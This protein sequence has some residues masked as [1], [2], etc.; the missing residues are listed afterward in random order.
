VPRR[1]ESC[2]T[3]SEENYSTLIAAT[4]GQPQATAEK[5][6]LKNV[7]HGRIGRAN[8]FQLRTT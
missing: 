5:P 3:L 7:Q 6:H 4:N 8:R 1:R 2:A